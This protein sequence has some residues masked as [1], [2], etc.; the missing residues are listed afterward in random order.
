[1]SIDYL[2]RRPSGRL[3]YFYRFPNREILPSRSLG[4]SAFCCGLTALS[5]G[6]G[7]RLGGASAGRRLAFVSGFALTSTLTCTLRTGL[8]VASPFLEL[9]AHRFAIAGLATASAGCRGIPCTSLAAG[10]L[11]ASPVAA[12]VSD[13]T[14]AGQRG[15]EALVA[16]AL[17]LGLAT[18]FRRHQAVGAVADQV[19]LAHLQQGFADHGPAE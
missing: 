10:G 13:G 11:V 8:A 16:A 17:G 4:C 15:L 1:M 3:F 5:G 9:R 19:A 6:F 14:V 2:K 7:T 12:L 18:A